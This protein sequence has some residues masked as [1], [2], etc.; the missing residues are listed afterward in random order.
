[1]KVY[2]S[3]KIGENEISEATRNKFLNAAKVLAAEGHEAF[4]PCGDNWVNYLK[5]NHERAKAYY[6]RFYS[7]LESCSIA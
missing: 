2:I 5:G 6:K 7:L 3:G 1:M 4:N